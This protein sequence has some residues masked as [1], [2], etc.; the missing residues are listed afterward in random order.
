[1]GQGWAI[2]GGVMTSDISDDTV[3]LPDGADETPMT[4]RGMGRRM[5]MKGAAGVV[6]AAALLAGTTE[7]ASAGHGWAGGLS[8]IPQD[9]L[10]D[11]YTKMTTSRIWETAMKDQF[12]AGTDQLYGAFHPYIGEE[13]VANGV[14]A[15]LNNDDFIA[16]THRG[17]GHLIAKG[18]DIDQ[19]S[20]E[21][22][23]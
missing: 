12:L 15:N 22:Y 19:M 13:A 18:G 20:A 3:R 7:W 23:W 17:H 9:K 11:I 5:F 10:I 1:E 21:I 16:S 14:I 6:G 8:H 2:F 4:R